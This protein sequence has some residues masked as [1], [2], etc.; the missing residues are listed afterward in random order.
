MKH[1]IGHDAGHDIEHAATIKTT[2]YTLILIQPLKHSL[3]ESFP[4]LF[5]K[6]NIKM[7]IIWDLA[8]K[9]TI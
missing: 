2:D 9:E 6:W 8:N 4:N 5:E 1:D 7:L 3:K